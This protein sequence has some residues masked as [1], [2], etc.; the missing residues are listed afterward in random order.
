MTSSRQSL[1]DETFPSFSDEYASSGDT[2]NNTDSYSDIYSEGYTFSTDDGEKYQCLPAR[3]VQNIEK[4]KTDYVSAKSARSKVTVYSV[5]SALDSAVDAVVNVVIPVERSISKLK[6]DS[7]PAS[8]KTATER[9]TSSRPFSFRRKASSS[10]KSAKNP[11]DTHNIPSSPIDKE[12][13]K[14]RQNP[15]SSSSPR[16]QVVTKEKRPTT[17]SPRSPKGSKKDDPVS[18]E[19]RVAGEPTDE[20]SVFS[21]S[22]ISIFFSSPMNKKFN[23]EEK[24][25][26][27]IDEN[28]EESTT[29]TRKVS[30]RKFFSSP[31]NKKVREEEIT[32]EPIE[33][34]EDESSSFFSKPFDWITPTNKEE[35]KQ[36]DEVVPVEEHEKKNKR[37]FGRR[38]N[39]K[40]SDISVVSQMTADTYSKE[41]DWFGRNK[42]CTVDQRDDATEDGNIDSN[43]KK[44]WKRRPFSPRRKFRRN[45]ED[46]RDTTIAQE[47]EIDDAD[48]QD[49]WSMYFWTYAENNDNDAAGLDAET[50]AEAEAELFKTESPKRKGLRKVFSR[51]SKKDRNESEQFHV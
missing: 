50:E 29:S 44:N 43:E 2:D 22:T 21:P 25:I 6:I 12:D 28:N 3:I 45:D 17:T 38:R 11:E 41:K 20:A 19:S 27:T 49:W 34:N 39:K 31:R 48:D 10:S 4:P 5:L 26:G 30:S 51:K 13:A 23:E 36:E 18:N 15:K 40:A 35:E 16:F 47:P 8:P 42:T 1:N 46:E 32:I 37:F 7:P 24:N 33:E 9:K 14:S